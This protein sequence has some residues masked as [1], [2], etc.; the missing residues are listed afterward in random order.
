MLPKSQF[1]RYFGSTFDQDQ[2]RWGPPAV[3]LP[4]MA[5][6][7]YQC[8]RTGLKVQTW[9]AEE[10]AAESSQRTFELLHCPACA[11]MHFVNRTT[12]KLLNGK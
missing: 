5:N 9:L 8:P 2:S 3:N 1:R 11:Q 12:G 4:A 6:I 10:P 7:L